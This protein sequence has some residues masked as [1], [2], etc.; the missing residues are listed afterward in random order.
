MCTPL[1]RRECILSRWD[2]IDENLKRLLFNEFKFK[3]NGCYTERDL[4]N[5]LEK[6][7]LGSLQKIANA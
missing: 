2:A 5:F 4:L 7:L 1:T 6:K 3:H